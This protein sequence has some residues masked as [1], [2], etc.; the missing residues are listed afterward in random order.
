MLVWEFLTENAADRPDK[1]AVVCG[2][3][4]VTYAELERASGRFAR[5]LIDRGMKPGDRIAILT[6]NSIEAAVAIFGIL[7]A[8]CV[9]LVMSQTIK[10]DKLEFILNDCGARGLVT[11]PV[12]LNMAAEVG[13]KVESLDLVVCC[14]DRAG[15]ERSDPSIVRFDP[16]Q[17]GGTV[18]L[19][20]TSIDADVAALIYTSGSTGFPKGVTVSHL[21]VVS[22][23]TSITTYLEN[24]ADDVIINAL[25]LSFD[26]GLY[27]LLMSVK[28]GATLVLEK[29]FAYP[30]KFIERIQQ[31]KVTGVP[32]VPTI[33][34]VL[35]QMQK[36]DPA[37]L[38]GVRYVT[39]TAAALH[40]TT[41]EK[42]RRLFRN[43]KVYSM[44]GLTECKRVSY[45]PPEELDRR[46]TSVGRGMPNERV[47]VVDEAGNPTPPG[48]VGEL[49]VTGS[50]VM[51]GYWNRPEETAEVIRPGRYPWQRVLHTGDLFTRDE[52]GF[53]YFVARKDDI[54]KSRGEK[55]SPSEVERIIY[56]ID[57]V[58]EAAVVGVPDSILG[59]A[60]KA[61]VVP[62]APGVL[63]A[64]EVVNHC[65]CRLESFMVPQQIE[66]LNDLPKTS[67]GKISRRKILDTLDAKAR[68]GE[69]GAPHHQSELTA[70]D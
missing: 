28:V 41:I 48:V 61:F 40:P 49:V 56:E 52:E 5:T 9:F 46:P 23:A 21:N 62:V 15:C 70:D 26:Y 65:A 43:A 63:T 35:L 60:V 24:T 14:G 11:D 42:I 50:N 4:R 37:L 1:T 44:Y 20:V 54:I 57:G 47:E 10:L 8:G 66:F 45:L 29:S 30:F 67:S 16:S 64:K 17:E 31:E 34:A 53:L 13:R 18:D 59:H 69:S 2:D 36:I 39:N 3:R 22:A 27:Q 19:E 38:D 25:P 32:G 68:G 6:E 55:V 33:F 12:F 58:R 51:L 7:R